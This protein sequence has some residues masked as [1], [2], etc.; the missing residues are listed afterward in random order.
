DERMNAFRTAQQNPAHKM[1]HLVEADG[2][3]DLDRGHAEGGNRGDAGDPWSGPP[4]WR[5]RARA[6][7]AGLGALSLALALPR[8]R[9]PRALVRR[10]L[11]APAGA[12]LLAGAAPRR[13]GPVCGPE[14]PG[15]PPYGG[16]PSRV[17]IRTLS[18]A[19]PEMRFDVLM[20]PDAPP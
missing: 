14:T 8:P 12:G 18:P 6:A 7:P 16:A 2:R 11:R 9:P 15:M 13:G 10:P 5:R 4:A 1:L 19:G 3:G 20:A 17:V